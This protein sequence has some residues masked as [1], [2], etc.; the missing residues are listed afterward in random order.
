MRRSRATASQLSQGMREQHDRERDHALGQQPR[1]HRAT[2]TS[3]GTG[4]GATVA[5]NVSGTV[6]YTAVANDFADVTG[7]VT[8]SLD[9]AGDAS[10]FSIDANTGEVTLVT[11]VRLRGSQDI[12]QLHG[13]CDGRGFEHLLEDGHRN[14]DKRRRRRADLCACGCVCCGGLCDCRGAGLHARRG[15]GRQLGDLQPEGC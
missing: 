6:V 2:I 5:E 3:G 8:Y 10:N 12:L 15:D 4:A 7:G 9:S 1:R 11:R 13:N 14:G